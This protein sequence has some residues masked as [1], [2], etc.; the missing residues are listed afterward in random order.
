MKGVASEFLAQTGHTESIFSD[1]GMTATDKVC[2]IFLLPHV[3]GPNADILPPNV[4]QPLLSAIAYAQ[5]INIAVRGRRSYTVEELEMIFDR[6]FK[7]LF[8]VLQSL[9]HID[10]D[11]RCRLHARNPTAH[12]APKETRRIDR[13][14]RANITLC[15]VNN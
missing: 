3:F 7:I 2:A 9:L 12:K 5:L 14:V 1:V 6:G 15:I 4:R 8:G 13:C 11:T 10:Y